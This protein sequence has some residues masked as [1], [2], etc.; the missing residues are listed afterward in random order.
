MDAARRWQA[1]S[2]A[3]AVVSLGGGALLI[4]HQTTEAL[5]PIELQIATVGRQSFDEDRRGAREP[6][7]VLLED[8]MVTPPIIES[9]R[10]PV[11]GP[12]TAPA[13]PESPPEPA[14]EPA[15]APVD[16]PSPTSPASVDS[17]SSLDSD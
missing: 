5:P 6:I 11:A 7:R 17:P 14:R 1:A 8:E 10:A 2:L 12:D 13:E 4:G 3:T 16:P 9:H 15:P